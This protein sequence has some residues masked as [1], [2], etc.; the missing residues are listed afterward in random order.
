MISTRETEGSDLVS[1]C[2]ANCQFARS[3][4]AIQ[5]SQTNSLRYKL[6]AQE[7]GTGPC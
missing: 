1:L 4:K 2:N 6:A 3:L 5:S 7:S